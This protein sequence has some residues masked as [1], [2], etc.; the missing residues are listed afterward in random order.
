VTRPV[1]LC[2]FCS[3][4][5]RIDASYVALAQEVGREIAARGWTLVTGG[6]S[7]SMMGAVA[8]AARAGGARTVGVIPRALV[9]MEVADH[10]ADELVVTEGM[11]DRKG[12]MDASADAFL[13]LP[14]GIGTLEELLEVWVARSLGM[15][16]KP[17]VVLDPDDVY[18]HL[19]AQVDALVEGGFVR[20]VA[21]AAAVWVR[22][23]DEAFEALDVGLAGRGVAA[24]PRTGREADEELLEADP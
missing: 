10:D 7:V 12:L 22:T 20:P 17:V 21:A 18:A 19:R 24:P 8:R 14:G 3:S 5:E 1:A 11:R 13:A 23:V 9:A 4:S 2:V 15:H 16:D 6:G